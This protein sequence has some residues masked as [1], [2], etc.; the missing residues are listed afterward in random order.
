MACSGFAAD[1]PTGSSV[2]FQGEHDADSDFV[3]YCT[4]DGKYHRRLVS[5]QNGSI[6]AENKY[7]NL[8]SFRDALRTVTDFDAVVHAPLWRVD[9][10]GDGYSDM[11]EYFTDGDPNMPHIIPATDT[12]LSLLVGE[13]PFSYPVN[14]EK[15]MD[16]PGSG[17]GGD[18]PGDPPA[19]SLDLGKIEL[20]L[21]A[22]VQLHAVFIGLFLWRLFILSKSQKN[23]I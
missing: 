3:Y 16:A 15:D 6:V 22:L 9:T 19:S 17:E 14:A 21:T 8:K 23:I 2:I 12:V 18:I 7:P 5:K 10:D 11:R 4:F 20:L 13:V 1:L